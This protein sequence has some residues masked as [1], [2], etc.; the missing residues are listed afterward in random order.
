M[1]REFGQKVP[2]KLRRMFPGGS[3][4]ATSSHQQNQSPQT[5]ALALLAF[6]LFGIVV[7]LLVLRLWAGLIS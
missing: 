5:T 3:R 2:T 1:N 4:I 6:G 7:S